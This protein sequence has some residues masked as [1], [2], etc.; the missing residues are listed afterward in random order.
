MS[1]AMRFGERMNINAIRNKLAN[2][3]IDFMQRNYKVEHY[4]DG[5]ILN[6]YD[7]ING[8]TNVGKNYVLDAAFNAGTQVGA[9]AWSIFL[10]DAASYSALAAGDTMASHGGWIEFTGYS[11]STRVAWGQGAASGQAI[12][13]ST[14]ATFDITS[15]GTLKGIGINSVSTKGGTTG[16]LWSTAL[17]TADV[18][19]ASADQL[20]ITYSL[21]C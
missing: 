18:P 21:G 2:D 1:Q 10:I 4:R 3:F 7:I 20:K 14:P 17:F 13:N 15:S 8:I 12:T 6:I 19:V 11:Q 16:T 5:K 9:G